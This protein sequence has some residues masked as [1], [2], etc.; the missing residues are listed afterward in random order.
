MTYQELQDILN[1]LEEDQLQMLAM[2]DIDDEYYNIK[3]VDVQEKNDR[4]DDGQPYFTV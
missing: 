3:A 2:I 1:E 4:I